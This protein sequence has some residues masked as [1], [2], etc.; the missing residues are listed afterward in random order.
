MAQTKPKKPQFKPL[1]PSECGRQIR[2]K[3]YKNLYFLYGRDTGALEPFAKKLTERLCPKESQMMNLHSFDV[4]DR[5]DFET[6]AD[7]LQVL[8]MFAERVIVLLSGLN[9]DTLTKNQGDILRKLVSDIPETTVFI[10]KAGGDK[11]YKNRKRLT[12]KNQR[13]SEHCAKY[14]YAVEFAFRSVFDCGKA[15][16]SSAER[17]GCGISKSNAEYLAKLCLCETA[18]INM[19]LDKLCAYAAGGEIDRGSIDALCVRRVESDGYS[20]ASN[21]LSGNAMFVFKRLD[22]LRAQNYEPTQI[23]AVISMSL[24]DIYRARLARSCGRTALDCAKDFDYGSS[25]DFAIRN[26]YEDCAGVNIERLRRTLILLSDTELRLKT[27]SLSADAAHLA[28]EQFAA[29]A[30]A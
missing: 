23:L 19:E 8:P 9:M 7:A 16:I 14:G 25:R 6:L 3:E 4:N 17:M 24:T 13:F 21:I 1:S 2:A 18:H 5:F 11:Q 29:N 22:E 20:L 26:A 15:I 30:M 27:A 28:V 12:D 10:I